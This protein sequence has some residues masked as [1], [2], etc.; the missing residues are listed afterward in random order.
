[1]RIQ[2]AQQR[3]SIFSAVPAVAVMTI[4]LSLTACGGGR[5]GPASSTSAQQD[6]ARASSA[7]VMS[8]SDVTV[9]PTEWSGQGWVTPAIPYDASYVVPPVSAQAYYV[10][11]DSGNDNLDGKSPANAWKSLSRVQATLAGQPMVYRSGDAILLRCSTSNVWRETLELDASNIASGETGLLISAYGCAAG[12]RPVIRGSDWVNSFVAG[13][14]IWVAESGGVYAAPYANAANV[15]QLFVSSQPV[16]RARHPNNGGVGAEFALTGPAT[17][18]KNSFTVSAADKILFSAMDVA[19]QLIG[20][21]VYVKN[22]PWQLRVAFVKGYA[23]DTGVITLDR[24]VTDDET[25]L[26]TDFIR[27]GAGYILEGKRWMLDAPGEWLADAGKLYYKDEAGRL[28]NAWQNAMEVVVRNDGIKVTGLRGLKIRGVRIEQHGYAGIELASSPNAEVKDVQTVYNQS[29]GI[30]AISQSGLVIEHVLIDN[31]GQAGIET[32]ETAGAQI[33][34]CHVNNTGLT[35][36]ALDAQPLPPGG[37]EGK[38]GRRNADA[39]IRVRG[40]GAKING[41]VVLRASNVGIQFRNGVGVEVKRNVV[42]NACAKFTDC[43]GIYT[44][45]G[46]IATEGRY[47]V[48]P[49]IRPDPAKGETGAS[50]SQNMVMGLRTVTE[51]IDPVIKNATAGIY[52]D[53]LSNQITVSNNVITGAERGIYLHD[54]LNNTIT[55]NTVRGATHAA[56][57]AGQGNQRSAD[58]MFG[59]KIE[60][61]QFFSHRELSLPDDSTAAP[62]VNITG[63]ETVA[64]AQLWVRTG[65]PAL[66]FAGSNPNISR[67]NVTR[68]VSSPRLP[69][70]RFNS[71]AELAQ[72]SGAVWGVKDETPGNGVLQPKN[73][74]AWQALTHQVAN[75]DTEVANVK[76]KPYAVSVDGSQLI[77]NSAMAESLGNWGFWTPPGSTA[78]AG[79]GRKSDC[80]VAFDSTCGVIAGGMV[81]GGVDKGAFVYSNP[82]TLTSS[83]GHKLYLLS[84]NVAGGPSGG[85]A[86]RV[87][88][89][90]PN[91]SWANLGVSLNPAK[92]VHLAANQAVRVEQFFWAKLPEGLSSDT[93]ILDL[94]SIPDQPNSGLTVFFTD[95]SV[96]KVQ[97]P[98]MLPPLN[99]VSLHLLNPTG[100]D[101]TVDLAAK[102][103]VANATSVV[104][105]EDDA[106][107]PSTVVIPPYG[108]KYLL[109]KPR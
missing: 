5:D 29:F 13:A 31:A 84:Y 88:L 79:Y 68:T 44:Y 23:K 9:T 56:F 28:P 51:A 100:I 87:F 27:A 26:T 91:G 58:V 19:T 47:G 99:E 86:Y 20:A 24:A 62:D 39:A 46:A 55:G 10:D 64:Y 33:L 32:F 73:L 42:V 37:I 82:F 67:N 6:Q 17:N 48:T 34:N 15:K 106:T 63:I 21:K 101:Q 95:V 38:D 74:A 76:L 16:T 22:D 50:V 75:V 53:E 41:N 69:I 12:Q 25:T 92:T 35:N 78:T 11:K 102:G 94:R 52:L 97:A 54:A 103:W 70:W 107:Q 66:F 43:A 61:N 90:Q 18:A 72:G 4:A 59:N 30:R 60:N 96:V 2:F 81:N 104:V 93:A 57:A 8:S 108:A 98:N 80:P 3:M 1:M 85:G 40:D 77:A 36:L 45:T 71:Y 49:A 89:R 109:R 65:D 7:S 105:D 14:S 83:T